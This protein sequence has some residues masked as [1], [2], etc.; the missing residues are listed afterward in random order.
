[1]KFDDKLFIGDRIRYHRKRLNLTQA[2]LAEKVDLSD[3]HLSK[4]ESGIYVPS[5]KTFFSLISVLKI[6]LREFG[7]NMENLQNSTKNKLINKIATATDSELIF[8][9]NLV[10]AVNIS[11]NKVKSEIL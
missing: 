7:F 3:Q 6:D 5:L 10:D 4:I 11:L 2:E 8:Y 9:E 1:M